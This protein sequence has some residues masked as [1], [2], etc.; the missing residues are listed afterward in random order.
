[1][2]MNSRGGLHFGGCMLMN[3]RGHLE[4]RSASRDNFYRSSG[5]S[6][7]HLALGKIGK[8][9]VFQFHPQRIKV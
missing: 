9:G 5:T 7:K 3:S 6:K 2:L 4:R 8:I 1:M